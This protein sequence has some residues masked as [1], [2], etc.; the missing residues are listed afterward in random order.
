MIENPFINAILN[1]DETLSFCHQ[2]AKKSKDRLFIRDALSFSFQIE[3]AYVGSNENQ[4]GPQF[5]RI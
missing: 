2:L 1:F 5:Q 3:K 4:N